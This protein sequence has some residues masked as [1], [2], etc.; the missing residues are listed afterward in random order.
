VWHDHTGYRIGQGWMEPDVSVSWPDQR[1]DGKYF[2]GSPMIAVEVLSPG[3][4]IDRKLTLYFADGAQEVW[5][6]D[7]KYRAITVYSQ[8]DDKVIRRVVDREFR[9]D[10]ANAAFSL[11]EIFG[12][13]HFSEVSSG[14]DT[15]IASTS[16]TTY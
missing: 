11:A 14:K 13:G 6:V 5:V 7:I 10:A 16:G 2:A 9:S 1:F 8:Q 4:E 15:R 12:E 3:E